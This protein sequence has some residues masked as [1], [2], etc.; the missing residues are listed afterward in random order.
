M[1]WLPDTETHDTSSQPKKVRTNPN[2]TKRIIFAPK[3]RTNHEKYFTCFYLKEMDMKVF[4]TLNL[5]SVLSS[6]CFFS[7][8]SLLRLWVL[9]LHS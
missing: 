1:R 7:S 8:R 6:F 9:V 4:G 2:S 5:V 3:V